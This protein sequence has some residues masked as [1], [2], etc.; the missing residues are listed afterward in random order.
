MGTRGYGYNQIRVRTHII[1]DSQIPVYYTCGYPFSYPSHAE[2]DFTQGYL[3]AWVF[4]F[5][6][7]VEYLNIFRYIP[8]SK[9]KFSNLCNIGAKR[10]VHGPFTGH[11][12]L[13]F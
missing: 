5:G 9:T 2:T 4:L 12:T 1:M 8:S 7:G 11:S 10:S 3:W 13:N 6:N